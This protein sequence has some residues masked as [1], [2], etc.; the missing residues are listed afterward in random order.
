MIQKN[1]FKSQGGKATRS[2]R[3]CSD[4]YGSPA[5]LHLKPTTRS[6]GGGGVRQA[7]V[8]AMKRNG[9]EP[10]FH[11]V[12]NQ[13][14]IHSATERQMQNL[15]KRSDSMSPDPIGSCPSHTHLVYTRIETQ[16][17]PTIPSPLLPPSSFRCIKFMASVTSD[18]SRLD[19]PTVRPKS[20]FR[21]SFSGFRLLFDASILTVCL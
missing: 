15:H 21:S 8:H 3:G 6:D 18:P 16:S 12:T 11:A 5:E 9:W 1:G 4:L 20:E 7:T 10:L 13:S 19:R 2:T 14:Q 17:V